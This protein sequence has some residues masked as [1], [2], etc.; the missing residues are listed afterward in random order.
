M[1]EQNLRSFF[2]NLIAFWKDDFTPAQKIG[3]IILLLLIFIG[4]AFSYGKSISKKEDKIKPTLIKNPKEPQKAHQPVDN[5]VV[6]HI[7]GA[8]YKP[9][10]YK[11]KDGDRVI[12]SIKKSGGALP[13]ADLNSLNLALKLADGQKIYV[14]KIGE[15]AQQGIAE[16]LNQTG[17]S[18]ATGELEDKVNIN[19]ATKEDLDKL[20]GIGPTLA[21]RIIEF[22]TKNGPFKSI[23]DLQNVE[24]IG[25]KKL[26][27]IKEKAAL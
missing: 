25:E 21:E 20:P 23:D 26:N 5:F 27:N 19:T 6:V 24:G 4:I 16:Q 9:G 15:I 12:D 17:I 18:S 14:P 2:D 7:A 10:V 1:I 3:A 22:R 11:L 8:V 13:K